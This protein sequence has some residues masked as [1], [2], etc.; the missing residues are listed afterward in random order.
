MGWRSIQWTDVVKSPLL[1][2]HFQFFFHNLWSGVRAHEIYLFFQKFI[3]IGF[4]HHIGSVSK[5]GFASPDAAPI[6]RHGIAFGRQPRML[7]CQNCRRW[8]FEFVCIF[9]LSMSHIPNYSGNICCLIS[10][11]FIRKYLFIV[12][13]L[14]CSKIAP[15]HPDF[16]Q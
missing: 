12:L 14:C 16:M 2:E 10:H 15:S 3:Y 9:A 7:A 5:F 13:M 8:S 6:W 1:L 11:K 4:D